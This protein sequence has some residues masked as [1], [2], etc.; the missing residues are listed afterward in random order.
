MSVQSIALALRKSPLARLAVLPALALLACACVGEPPASTPRDNAIAAEATDVA[1]N[2]TPR[3]GNNAAVSPTPQIVVDFQEPP[4]DIPTSSKENP[5]IKDKEL[6]DEIREILSSSGHASI[7]ADSGFVSLDERILRSTIIARATMKSVSPRA[8]GHHTPIEYFPILHFTF[9]VH[10]YLKGSGNSLLTAAIVIS[11]QNL[12]DCRPT[13]KQEAI[14][15]ANSWISDKSNRWWED[16]ESI[17]FLTEDKLINSETSAQSDSIIYKF[18]HW[19]DYRNPVYNYA[20]THEPYF[21]GDEYSILSERNRVWLP[22]TAESSGASGASESRFM[23]GETPKDLYQDQGV[24]RSSS[25]DTDISLSDLKSRVKAVAD[26]V[27]QGEDVAVYEECLRQ[28]YSAFRSPH[29]P[30]TREFQVRV[31]LWAGRVVDSSVYAGD[32][33]DIFFLEGDD[34]RF[35]EFDIRDADD[36]PFNGYSGR[37]KTT[38]PLVRGDYSVMYHRMS[39]SIMPCIDASAGGRRDVPVADVTWTIR[40]TAPARTLHEAFFDPV[41]IGAAVGADSAN[42]ILTPAA[43]PATNAAAQIRRIDWAS[44]AVTIEIANPPASLANH[45]IDF[46]ALDGAIALRLA[47]GDAAIADAGAVRAFS[48]G[49][50]GRPWDAGDM[51]MLRISESAPGLEGVAGRVACEDADAPAPSAPPALDSQPA[52]TPAPTLR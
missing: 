5:S 25:F 13:T 15:Y 31:A 6:E 2:P 30:Y 16:R 23:L 51:L 8:R 42:G 22:A 50:C 14:D 38:R 12:G 4:T 32:E 49:V 17:I 52:Q 3:N 19:V 44:D 9:D 11:C 20:F 36:D 33:Y 43:F 48:W 39:G 46:I 7:M 28:K 29:G 18:I 24:A 40:V 45:H 10:E 41:A 37:L 1:V 21:G 35:F 27:K 47:F 34:K 26:M